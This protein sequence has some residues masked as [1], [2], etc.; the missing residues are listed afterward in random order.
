MPPNSTFCAFSPET[1]TL[2]SSNI[3]VK[4]RLACV[5]N[6]ANPLTKNIS[7]STGNEYWGSGSSLLNTNAPK[8]YGFITTNNA[9]SSTS[10]I[11]IWPNKDNSTPSFTNNTN[12]Y[13]FPYLTSTRINTTSGASSLQ[14]SS[15]PL[16]FN[17]CMALI[18]PAFSGNNN[19][20]YLSSSKT[21]V[22]TIS[23]KNRNNFDVIIDL[24]AYLCATTINTTTGLAN[25][26]SALY[27]P[28][29]VRVGIRNSASHSVYCIT[30]ATTSL[31][32]INGF[33]LIKGDS[34]ISTTITVPANGFLDIS[35]MK[36]IGTYSILNPFG[37]SD[38]AVLFIDLDG[39]LFLEPS[40][41]VTSYKTGN[42]PVSKNETDDTYYFNYLAESTQQ[43]PDIVFKVQLDRKNINA[44]DI[45]SKKLSN[46]LY[47]GTELIRDVTATVDASGVATFA[48]YS[49]DNKFIAGDYTAKIFYDVN[50][51]SDNFYSTTSSTSIYPDNSTHYNSKSES[52]ALS[53]KFKI[54]KQ[55]LNLVYNN[56]TIVNQMNLLN[57][58]ISIL[59]ETVLSNFTITNIN[60]TNITS[61]TSGKYTLKVYDFTTLVYSLIDKTSLNDIKFT[62]SSIGLKH[63]KQYNFTLTFVPDNQN[64]SSVTSEKYYFITETPRLVQVLKVNNSVVSNPTIAYNTGLV[65]ESQL[66]DSYGNVYNGNSPSTF[67]I[68]INCKLYID[69]IEINHSMTYNAI[70]NKFSE[71]ISPQSLSLL[72]YSKTAYVIKTFFSSNN[73]EVINSNVSNFVFLG[74]DIITTINTQNINVYDIVEVLS[75]IK[76]KTSNEIYSNIIVPG[77]MEYKIGNGSNLFKTDIINTQTSE[78]KYSYS[79]IPN[80]YDINTSHSPITITTTFKFTDIQITNAL[81]IHDNVT[82]SLITPT[83]YITPKSEINDYHYPQ[84]FTVTLTGITSHNDKGTLFLYGNSSNRH[85]V[86]KLENISLNSTVHFTGIDID[87]LIEDDVLSTL[88]L[89]QKINGMIRWAPTNV[90][91]YTTV[92]DTFE[93][94]LSITNVGFRNVNIQNNRCIFTDTITIVGE[95]SSNYTEQINGVVELY[96]ILSPE[97]VISSSNITY[98]NLNNIFSL[99]VTS[100]I[101]VSFNF[102]LRFIPTY[103]NVYSDA[104]SENPSYFLEF[105]KFTITPVI[106]VYDLNNNLLLTENQ[107]HVVSMTYTNNFRIIVDNLN[108]LNGTDIQVSIGSEY[109]S[110]VLFV[111]NGQVIIEP[112]NY[113]IVNKS[114]DTQI[115]ISSPKLISLNLVGYDSDSELKQLY[116]VSIPNKY[117]QFTKNT[118]LPRLR[119]ITM[120]S[121]ETNTNSTTL[122]Y[123]DEFE[124]IGQ[125]NLSKD[126]N[127]DIIEISGVLKLYVDSMLAN[128][129][130]LDNLL[131]IYDQQQVIVSNFK[132]SNYNIVSGLKTFFFEFVPF[133]SNIQS[134]LL[135]NLSYRIVQSTI[136]DVSLLLSPL[137][138]N[139]VTYYKEQ[140]NGVL[141]F[142]NIGVVGDMEV[143]CQNP[144]EENTLQRLAVIPIVT[145]PENKNTQMDMEFTCDPILFD[146]PNDITEYIIVV[147]FLSG[148]PTRFDSNIMPTT[149]SYSIAKTNIRLNNLLLNGE[150]WDSFNNVMIVN[151]VLSISGKFKTNQNMDVTSGKVAIIA[152]IVPSDDGNYYNTIDNNLHLND[153]MMDSVTNTSYVNVS[154]TGEFSCQ[155]TLTNTSPLYTNVGTYFQIVYLNSKNYNDKYCAY[156]EDVPFG[157]Y[158]LFVNDK[159]FNSDNIV[160]RLESSTLTNSYEF[161]YHEDVMHFTLVIDELYSNIN[162]SN[163]TMYLYDTSNNQPIGNGSVMNMELPGF[164][165]M[166]LLPYNKTVSTSNGTTTKTICKAEIYLNPKTENINMNMNSNYS[167]SCT[168]SSMGY[169]PFTQILTNIS[170]EYLTF[171][172]QPTQP[173][174]NIEFYLSETSS[175]LTSPATINFEQTVNM[176]L[177]IKPSYQV[178]SRVAVTQDILGQVDFR[179]QNAAGTNYDGVFMDVHLVNPNSTISFTDAPYIRVT[180]TDSGNGTWNSGNGILF[181]YSPKTD[182][183]NMDIST[184]GNI[185][186]SFTPTYTDYQTKY[187]T[188]ILSKPF[189]VTKY[190]P[191]LTINSLSIIND[192][193]HSSVVNKEDNKQVYYDDVNGVLYN[194]VLN[195]DEGFR[196][197]CSLNQNISG[198]LEYYYSSSNSST[199]TRLLPTQT[200]VS[201]GLASQITNTIETTFNPQLL[202]IPATHNYNLKVVFIPTPTEPLINASYTYASSE[203]TLLPFNIYQANEFG[204]GHIHWDNDLNTNTLK[205]LQYVNA[206]AGQAGLSIEMEYPSTTPAAARRFSVEVYHT[207]F[208]TPSNKILGPYVLDITTASSD[209]FTAKNTYGFN[210][211]HYASS[212][213]K[214]RSTPYTI[215][216]K[217]TPILVDNTRNLNYPIIVEDVPLSLIVKPY[218]NIDQTNPIN[219]QYSDP[220]SFNVYLN[221]GTNISDASPYNYLIFTTTSFNSSTYSKRAVYEVNYSG[222]Q[223]NAT[224]LNDGTGRI[225]IHIDN[226]QNIMNDGSSS[227]VPGSYNLS[228]YATN[229]DDSPNMRT[230]SQTTRFNIS[231]K[232]VTLNTVFEK[233]NLSYRQSNYIDFNLGNDSTPNMFPLTNG[234]VEFT[235]INCDT[236]VT[237]NINILSSELTEIDTNIYRYSIPDM[238]NWLQ[239]GLYKVS[240]L[241]N[242]TYYSG[243]KAENPDYLLLVN[244]E[245]NCIIDMVNNI[246]SS[247]IGNDVSISSLVKYND[248]QNI[249]S[250]QLSLIINNGSSTNVDRNFT[251]PSSS[252]SKDINNL[253]L[254]YTD[255]NYVARSLPFQ[256]NILKQT[257]NYTMPILT[258]NNSEDTE[259][260]FKLHLSNVNESDTILFY[261]KSSI[262]HL[263]PST[264]AS[265]VYT[266]NYSDLSYGSNI[267]YAVIRTSSYDSVTSELIV[268]RNR[269]TANVTLDCLLSNSYKSNSVVDIR[270]RVSNTLHSSQVI[271]GGAIEYHCV[272]YTDDGVN[273]AHDDIIG[274]VNVVNNVASLTSY[275]LLGNSLTRPDG[276]FYDNKIKFYAKYINSSEYINAESDLTSLITVTTKLASRIIDDTVLSNSYHLGDTVSLEC[277]VTKALSSYS[278]DTTDVNIREKVNA[279][280]QAIVDLQSATELFA[281]KNSE[282]QLAYQ[283]WQQASVVLDSKYERMS[284]LNSNKYTAANAITTAQN[285]LVTAKA[286]L[287]AVVIDKVDAELAYKTMQEVSKLSGVNFTLSDAQNRVT[288]AQNEYNVALTNY[289]NKLAIYNNLLASISSKQTNVTNKNTLTT[290]TDAERDTALLNVSTK[291]T[292]LNSA[293]LAYE[294]AVVEH[295]TALKN[296][297]DKQAEIITLANHISSIE[298]DYE[299]K[300]LNYNNLDADYHAKQ[301]VYNSKLSVFSSKQSTYMDKSSI[302][303]TK[304][305]LYNNKVSDYNNK[306]TL[307]TN[308][309]SNYE[310]KQT[311]FENKSTNLLDKQSIS[312]SKLDNY[313]NNLSIFNSALSLYDTK[314]AEY[315]SYVQVLLDA[316]NSTKTVYDTA[317]ANYDNNHQTYEDNIASL[318]NTISNL[319]TAIANDPDNQELITERDNA[320]QSKTTNQSNLD[321]LVNAKNTAETNSQTAITAYDNRVNSSQKS[322]MD[323]ALTAKNTAETEKNNSITELDT[324][325][326]AV[327]VA[328]GEKSTAETERDTALS[329]KSTAESQLDNALIVKN[330]AKAEMDTAKAEMDTAKAE[331]DVAETEK[332]AANTEMN[333]AHMLSQQAFALY[334]P[335]KTDYD[336]STSSKTRKEAELVPLTS[337][338]QTKGANISSLN[339]TRTNYLSDLDSLKSIYTTKLTAYNNAKTNYDS[340]NTELTNLKQQLIVLTNGQTLEQQVNSLL[341]IKNS[342]YV[343]WKSYVKYCELVQLNSPASMDSVISTMISEVSSNYDSKYSLWKTAIATVATK[344]SEYNN[345]VALYNA[346]DAEITPAYIEVNTA[347]DSLNVATSALTNATTAKQ[348]AENNRNTTRNNVSN[349]LSE[350]AITQGYISFYKKCNESIQLL[351]TVRPNE[352][353]IAILTHNLIDLGEVKFYAK[354]EN[355]LDY[356]DATTDFKTTQVY[357]KYSDIVNNN[358]QFN[359]ELYKIGDAVNLSFAVNKADVNNTPITDG[360]LAI[361]KKSGV[362]EQLLKYYTLNGSNNGI[363][364]HSD[365]LTDVGQ[366]S[367]YAKYL[368]SV[369]NSD[370]ISMEKSVLVLKELNTTIVDSTFQGEQYKLGDVINLQYNFTSTNSYKVENTFETRTAAITEGLVE[371]HKLVSSVDEIISFVQLNVTNNG[372]ISVPHTFTDVGLVQFY[373]VYR[374]TQNYEHQSNSGYKRQANVVDKYIAQVQNITELSSPISKKV[375]E[376]IQLK[377]LVTYNSMPLHEGSIKVNKSFVVNG[378]TVTEILGYV[379]VDSNGLAVFNYKLVDMNTSVTFTGTYVNSYNYKQ[380]YDVV[381]TVVNVYNKYDSLIRRTV[382]FTSS[383]ITNYKLGDMINIEYQVTNSLSQVAITDGY[384]HIHKVVVNSNG[385]TDEILYSNTPNTSTGLVS[386]NYRV[387][388]V[389]SITFY[390]A[391]KDSA[392]YA[393]CVSETETISSIKEYTTAVNTLTINNSTPVYGDVLTLTSNIVDDVRVINEGNVLFY[394][395]IGGSPKELIGL[396]NVVNNVASIQYTVNDMNS[397]VFSSV[398]Q[399]TSNFVD[400]ESLPV[401][402]N[403]GKTNIQSIVL[404]SASVVQFDI[405]SVTATVTYGKEL[406]YHELGKVEFSI[407]NNGVTKTTQV[408]II[409]GQ[410]VYKL[411]VDNMLNYVVNAKF[412]TNAAFN[413]SAPVSRTLTPVANT[414]YNSLTFTQTSV[415]QASNYKNIVAT[416]SFNNVSVDELFYLKNTGFVVFET[417]LSGVLQ[418][419]ATVTVPLVDSSAS[420][421]VRSETNYTYVVKYVDT[422]TSPVITIVGAS[423]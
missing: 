340:A 403:I 38:S 140:F 278:A 318:T 98:V 377:F 50:N 416:M 316:K 288:N 66:L 90:N 349:I 323:S 137:P 37:S 258:Y 393:N 86:A 204:R 139:D 208:E 167:A 413:E 308:A 84:D 290:N 295:E 150:N 245:T 402:R 334:T 383:G 156:E 133:D 301:T 408:D 346:N 3:T 135:G 217:Y 322:D 70:T 305:T 184:I 252:L 63:S 320:V 148:D 381:S 241:L 81:V 265:G 352:K 205:T 182:G 281:A 375:G 171:N 78:F 31:S 235:I 89:N 57:N 105:N 249:S 410:A 392:D 266:F 151:D 152:Y 293:Q 142:Y 183:H 382:P 14:P 73:I 388:T 114:L 42:T 274:Y 329:Q 130:I 261:K 406:C 165:S 404:S 97:I 353:G 45:I 82:V 112:I 371:V 177:T 254:Y 58:Q 348:T 36:L 93:I 153:S 312:Q 419:N 28:Y 362:Y 75:F 213:L 216:A 11:N 212:G 365:I 228:V 282:Y 248:V 131:S 187:T 373:V 113:M 33:N 328:Q 126:T 123:D 302:N 343:T 259:T 91:I 238:S 219:Q 9:S 188:A 92:Q 143:Y 342:K 262:S 423:A 59:K 214:Y 132:P 71:T 94:N 1:T 304:T 218:L 385:T 345:L 411:Y 179:N 193:A 51:I 289:N 309:V 25:V 356:Y 276:T 168:I 227:L 107:Q 273:I 354:I 234:Q 268:T 344:N 319:D 121:L 13:L 160:F 246:Y 178:N 186:T 102:G 209:I 351:G 422:V 412:L 379:N 16:P 226:F 296:M 146:C 96:D 251:V 99:P 230:N 303:D 163:V 138:G 378:T 39:L 367:Y 111:E 376:Q 53:V 332:N 229:V 55:T 335:V 176:K 299:T 118:V 129:I 297:K 380:I 43:N 321:S 87:N 310:S 394:V 170:G 7:S 396:A 103:S 104:I 172:V 24:K 144:N 243:S 192:V 74:L 120:K 19:F 291:E 34:R 95:L 27:N 223:Q 174:I 400:V 149:F 122:N 260:T 5:P 272:Q 100:N 21:T 211:V 292:Q 180:S 67:D 15:V 315:N 311:V 52:S 194:S 128:P 154:S 26:N 29:G 338:E 324:A 61:T 253:V 366:V 136:T 106:N 68:N 169:I 389:G 221:V 189:R 222:P 200:V 397:V 6:I 164:Y 358:S 298:E 69:D 101:V 206:G 220:V 127:N 407:V 420:A 326:A 307:V 145:T 355:A 386:Y 336:S 30:Q 247:D 398:F 65:I 300:Q 72:R 23:I 269:P 201:T 197:V 391:F 271:T 60:N 357:E 233:Y 280:Q 369:N 255:S 417:Y 17:K 56:A 232:S 231:K 225:Q 283:A 368:N 267:V 236:S 418:S 347:T 116:S 4:G 384:I 364:T 22:Q 275:K 110:E 12:Y 46:R 35:L 314:T 327:L 250:G 395:E 270:Y 62:G 8:S 195:Y 88:Q 263:V 264:G 198:T 18:S 109:T 387:D 119:N 199:F 134:T 203:S 20:T 161:P 175:L 256:V 83:I 77:S 196:V 191:V 374:G 313:N 185:Y 190:Q 337:I 331:M 54:S 409:N 210:L 350:I 215:R 40:L 10:Y 257:S 341:D 415:P 244:K 202:P 124:I 125:F 339:T 333:T 372:A 108:K 325:E 330:A 41:S 237:T 370:A 240:A 317:L 421:K 48:F 158:Q 80:D 166:E 285:N 2:S 294:T 286:A 155:L 49:S 32:S 405:V 279:E 361:Y 76:D 414:N 79:F 162:N 284:Q 287:D 64:V 157:I 207:D 401:E 115:N 141:S 47:Q 306:Q 173:V 224:M 85:E 159:E 360:Q 359:N 399:N 181:R 239:T 363:I 242:N 390:A 44:D 277:I 147:K 117:I